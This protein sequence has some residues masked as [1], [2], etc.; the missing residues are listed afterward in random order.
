MSKSWRDNEDDLKYR[1]RQSVRDWRDELE[2]ALEDMEQD[3]E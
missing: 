1:S 3:C 2:E